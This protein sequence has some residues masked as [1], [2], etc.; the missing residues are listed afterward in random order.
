VRSDVFQDHKCYSVPSGFG[1]IGLYCIITVLY[2]W[3]SGY[4]LGHLIVSNVFFRQTMLQ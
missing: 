4:L 1:H 3:A 2:N